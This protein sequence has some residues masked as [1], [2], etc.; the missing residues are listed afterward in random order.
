[1]P[2]FWQ[3]LATAWWRLAKPD[4]DLPL[5]LIFLFSSSFLLLSRAMNLEIPFSLQFL[6]KHMFSPSRSARTRNTL[7]PIK[8]YTLITELNLLL[9]VYQPLE[10]LGGPNTR[11]V[12]FFAYDPPCAE[13]TQISSHY[14]HYPDLLIIPHDRQ[15][16]SRP[17]HYV[18]EPWIRT[19]FT[20]K[21][22]IPFRHE[23]EG[24]FIVHQCLCTCFVHWHDDFGDNL[25]WL[26]DCVMIW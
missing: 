8:A 17:C 9:M 2:I 15:S 10:T 18:I 21:V 25:S 26:V 4:K 23:F 24:S 16:T 11:T 3:E 22:K 7:N 19:F 13:P 12:G 6:L 1:M 20:L 14:C 5:V